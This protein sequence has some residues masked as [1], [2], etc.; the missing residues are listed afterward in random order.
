MR[1]PTV[2]IAASD[3]DVSAAE[4][5]GTAGQFLSALRRRGGQHRRRRSRRPEGQLRR[6]LGVAGPALQPVPRRRRHRPRARGVPSRQRE[7]C[8]ASSGRGARPRRRPASPSTRCTTARART[9]SLRAKAEAQRRSRDAYA[10][11]FEIGQRDLLDVLDAENELFLARVGLV[12]AEYTERFAVYRL[13]AVTGDLLEA[14]RSARRA[15]RSTSTGRPADVQTPDAVQDKSKQ[16]FDP[17]A[18]PRALRG[19]DRRRAAARG[20]GRCHLPAPTRAG[21]AGRRAIVPQALPPEHLPSG[22][23]LSGLSRQ[24]REQRCRLLILVGAVDMMLRL[25]VPRA[26]DVERGVSVRAGLSVGENVVQGEQPGLLHKRAEVA[27]M[28]R[29]SR[30][31]TGGTRG[32]GA[33][34]MPRFALKLSMVAGAAFVA[35]VAVGPATSVVVAQSGSS[36]T[37]RSAQAVRRRLRAGARGVCRGGH[38]READRVRHQRHAL[39]ARS[40][41]E[42]SRHRALP[43]HAG[44]DPRRVRR[45]RHRGHDGERPGQGRLADRRHAGGPGRHRGRRLHHPHRRRAGHWA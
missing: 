4:L 35:G 27:G 17:R 2:Q 5:R 7:P 10:Q 34:L 30:S 31:P 12:T 44:A 41:F 43:R 23:S 8:R 18:E 14:S 13:L 40:A 6:R 33:R 38:R 24:R 36:D 26:L 28:A 9:A 32:Q 42:L 11:Q 16:L 20:A 21:S 25:P 15:R 29:P 22:G 37:F 19:I 3:V 1:S 39:V 45:A